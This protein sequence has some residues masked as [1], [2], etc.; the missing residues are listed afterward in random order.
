MASEQNNKKEPGILVL[1]NVVHYNNNKKPPS[2]SLEH[3]QR[4]PNIIK[5]PLCYATLPT[6]VT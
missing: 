6:L 3:W 4:T 5:A 2:G 1:L